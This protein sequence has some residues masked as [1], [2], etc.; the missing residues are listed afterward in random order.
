MASNSGLNIYKASA[1]SGKTF[2]LVGEYLKMLFAQ[3]KSYRNILAVTFTNKATAEMKERILKELGNL[4]KGSDSRYLELLKEFGSEQKI[5]GKAEN[6][7]KL[8]L[9]DYSRFSVM[10]IDSFF[11][12]VIRAFA[13]EI[14]LNASF[15]TEIDNR[16]A[17]EEA[18]DLL[19]QEI[20]DNSL[21]MNWMILFLEENLEEGR[22]WDFRQ[23]LLKFGKE[24]EKEAFKIYGDEFVESLASK[25]NLSRYVQEIKNVTREADF[26]LRKI[27]QEAIELIVGSGMTIDQFKGGKNTFVNIFNKLV[28]GKFEAPT[29]TALEAR[30][31]PENW[32]KKMDTPELKSQIEALY[33]S[34]LNKL[35]NDAVMA[36]TE[37]IPKINSAQAILKNIY[38][39][40]LLGNIALKI[41][42]VLKDNN[43]VLL[44]DS[45][46]MIGKI[47]EGNDTPFIYEKVGLIY[48]HFMLDEFQDTSVQQWQNFKPLVE[49]ALASGYSSLVVGDVKQSIYRWR[50]GDWNLLA[51]QLVHDLSHQLVTEEVL[52]KNWRSRKSIVDFNNTLFWSASAFLNRWFEEES[53]GEQFDELHGVIAQA[54]G[55]PYQICSHPGK[56]EGHVKITFVDAEEA[57]SK[58]GFREKALVHLAEQLEEVQKSGVKAGEITILVRENS[59]AG[60]I[61]KALWE[62][63]KND[64]QPGC[65]YDVI[66]SDTLKIGQSQVVRFV[67]NFFRFFTRKEPQK[68]RAEILYGYYWILKQ[69]GLP[70]ENELQI[71]LHGLFDP[72]VP[73]PELFEKWLDED[74]NSEFVTG[75]LALPLYE[76]AVSIVDHFELGSIVGE[77]LFL[78]A[79]L[80]MVLEYGRD[81]YG[82]IAGFLDWWEANGSNKTLNLTN[83]Q[84][85][86]RISSIHQSKGLEYPTVF[87]PFC[88]WEVGLNAHKLPYIWSIPEI[89][90]F[91]NLKMVLLKCES[92]LRNSIFSYDY[93]KEL[94]YSILDNL[95]LLYVAATRAV[96][97]LFIIMPY[98]EEIKKPG[99]VAELVQTLI[100]H[101]L[102]LD[103]IDREK[104]SDFGKSWDSDR[105]VFELGS[106]EINR[107]QELSAINNRPNEPLLLSPS[108]NRMKIRLHSKDYFQLTGNRQVERINKGTIMHQIFEKIKTRKDIG[109][110]VSQMVTSGSLNFGEGKAIFAKIDELLQQEPFA[111]WFS[112]QWRVL[113]E[114]DIL[115]VGESKHRPDRVLLKDNSAVVI[116]YKTGE[117]SDKDI[118]QM[119]G[120]LIDLQKMGYSSC[121][122]NIWYLQ[123]NEVVKVEL[124][125]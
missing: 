123:K 14:R 32:Y 48:H 57:K 112:D 125:T 44:S 61:A 72:G 18:I 76:L 95:N 117:K 85:F 91:S 56:P 120:Y 88:N 1:G 97:N 115:R 30:D 75:L 74:P 108:S 103:S 15:R 16:Q 116:D 41:K 6:I 71:D 39:F 23:E 17:L 121:E 86:I 11:Q 43:T 110:A 89:E 79:F 96:N 38:P 25:E 24:V 33:H 50:N 13:R 90:P 109:D 68:V 60:K 70:E 65:I 55:D 98:K 94:L 122:G 36:L 64:P 20:D 114:R 9:H 99:N 124:S 82:G 34:G 81:D 101:P 46:R 100:E 59:E 28:N 119:K 4:S 105:K 49:N 37:E 87:I 40:G 8:I 73:L 58:S 53:T 5:R 31:Y 47:I 52:D 3:P 102:L 118:R 93:N 84:N 63:K 69:E 21:L 67:V 26:R 10:T 19:F 66:T 83:I 2:L 80:D 106:L 51:N 113:N 7:L 35:L 107:E 92:S 62:R 54:Y 12:K 42:E 77:K 29:K 78:Q 27:G 45:G 104:Y 22:S 111:N